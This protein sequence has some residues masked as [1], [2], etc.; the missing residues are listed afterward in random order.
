MVIHACVER[1]EE[2]PVMHL[3]EYR[4]KVL[5]RKTLHRFK[6]KNG[7]PNIY[8]RHVLLQIFPV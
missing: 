5:R 1:E 6:G 7:S 8:S 3:E 2:R 4:G